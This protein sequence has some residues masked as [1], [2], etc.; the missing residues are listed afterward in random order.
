MMPCADAPP[1]PTEGGLFTSDTVT[2]T[3]SSRRRVGLSLQ[4]P[5]GLWT[6]GF[7]WDLAGRLT[8]VT[9]PLDSP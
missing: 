4:Q 8:N 9:S 7:G 3:Y 2:N 6:N 1:R 5:T